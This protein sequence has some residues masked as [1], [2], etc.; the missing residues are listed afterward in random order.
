M[1]AFRTLSIVLGL[2]SA[3]DACKPIDPDPKMATNSELIIEAVGGFVG[4]GAPGSRF[5]S[6]GRLPLAALTPQDQARVQ[7]LF[8]QPAPEKTN[9]YYRITIQGP[10]GSKTIDARPET[11]PEALL[12]S[13]QSKLD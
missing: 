7:A 3:C 6:E 4:E 9:F 5:H 10:D 2:L 12:N 11:V 1:R 8:S 13:I